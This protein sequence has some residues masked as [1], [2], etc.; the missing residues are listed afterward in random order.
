MLINHI[1]ETKTSLNLEGVAGVGKTYLLKKLVMAAIANDLFETIEILTL[2]PE[3]WSFI[4]SY[5]T[6][7]LTNL[8]SLMEKGSNSVTTSK[9][10]IVDGFSEIISY[11]SFLSKSENVQERRYFLENYILQ[12]DVSS[13]SKI[14][15]SDQQECLTLRGQKIKFCSRKKY[16]FEEEVE[17]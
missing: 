7:E 6:V 3:D 11:D 5:S 4:N 14:C 16:I 8:S 15:V 12:L 1:L 9:L 13:T 10:M 17:L 2:Y